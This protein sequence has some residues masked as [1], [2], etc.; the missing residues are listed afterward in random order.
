MCRCGST[1]HWWSPGCDLSHVMLPN[2]SWKG[3]CLPVKQLL[4][5]RLSSSKMRWAPVKQ[6]HAQ[7]SLQRAGALAGSDGLSQ[8]IPLPPEAH[9]NTPSCAKPAGLDPGR[10][11]L[12]DPSVTYLTYASVLLTPASVENVPFYG[13]GQLG[14]LQ[15]ISAQCQGSQ[16]GR[17]RAHR[18]SCLEGHSDSGL[19]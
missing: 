16:P 17:S 11:S 18:L 9:T 8:H 4:S 1:T 10:P 13:M 7:H 6:L 3:F 14:A 15:G 12:G 5:P 2:Q 19:L